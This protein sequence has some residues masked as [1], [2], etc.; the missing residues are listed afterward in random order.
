[1]NSLRFIDDLA[2]DGAL[3]M[4][5]DNLLAIQGGRPGAAVVLRAYSWSGP[6]LSCGFHQKIEERV[7]FE[8]C[9]RYGVDIVRRPTGGRELLHNGDLS[10]SISG[11]LDTVAIRYDGMFHARDFFFKVCQVI[12]RGLE[13]LG[14]KVSIKPGKKK[15]RSVNFLPC[16]ATSAQ[17]EIL[18]G[19]KKVVPMAQRLYQHSVL[20]HGSIP[21]AG[22]M[23]P[24]AGLLRVAEAD[25]LQRQ[26]DQS[27]T[28]LHQLLGVKVDIGQLK[29]HLWQSFQEVYGGKI[30]PRPLSENEVARAEALSEKWGFRILTNALQ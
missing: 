14:I 6:T 12:S 7:D 26:I 1:M 18:S 4:A 10:F 28:N 27:S 13:A 3:N 17:Y 15:V 25:V 9:R 16:L 24:T 30:T 19:G 22:S 23:I 29:R 2:R 20:V 5:L 8:G 11:Y 21:L